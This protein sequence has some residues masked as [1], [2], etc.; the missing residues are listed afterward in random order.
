MTDWHIY[1]VKDNNAMRVFIDTNVVMDWLLEDRPAKPFAK[2]I[3]TAA[4]Q[5]CFELI[6]STQSIID[7]SYFSQKSG[8][9]FERISDTLRYLY[10]FAKIVGIDSIDCLWAIDHYSGDFE[11]DMQYAS[12]YNAVCDYFIT[13]DKKLK[14]LN[15]E[16]NPMKVIS[17]EDFVAQ[18][19][20][21]S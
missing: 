5:H 20:A 16:H 1:L 9:P 15:R 10:T 12:A 14:Q 18:M 21:S 13:R 8:M 19:M 17:P 11:D 7:T 6:I 3:I 2:T 4:E